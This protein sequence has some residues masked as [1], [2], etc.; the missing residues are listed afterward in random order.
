MPSAWQSF[1]IRV[2]YQETDQMG[3]VYHTNIMNWFEWGRTE[4]IR[5]YG[6]TYRELEQDQLM[7]PVVEAGMKLHKPALY[8]QRLIIKTRVSVL[9]PMLVRFENEIFAYE[10]ESSKIAS[11]FTE[12]VWMSAQTRKIIRLDRIAPQW[13]ERL[14]STLLPIIRTE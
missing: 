13:Y 2:R 4:W 3:V 6:F 1:E 5:A 8:D 11:G 12:H 9:Q 7:L 10:D 14:K